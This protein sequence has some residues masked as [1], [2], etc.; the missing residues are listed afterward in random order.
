MVG[1]RAVVADDHRL[2]LSAVS[3]SLTLNGIDVVARARTAGET[4]AAVQAH[5]PDVLVIDLDLGPGPTGCD[6]ASTLRERFPALGIVVLSGY[7]DPRFLS[8]A[9]DR[10]PRGTVYLVKQ[11][12]TDITSVVDA[13]SQACQAVRDGRAARIP[14]VQLTS[15]QI[16]VLDRISKGWS[17]VAIAEDLY[18]TEDAVSKQVS[19]IAKRLGV[20]RDHTV[21]TRV[22]LARTYLDLVANRR[23]P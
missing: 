21:N 16:A 8:P 1:I 9:S 5:H 6:I 18:I 2:T 15:A 12:L 22:A 7:A 3:D 11:Q 14:R 20:H 17:N 23:D 13:V 10:F 4:M 19:R